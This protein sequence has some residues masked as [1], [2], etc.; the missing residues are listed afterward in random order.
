MTVLT[1]ISYITS[2]RNL[3]TEGDV[4]LSG[5]FY[6]FYYYLLASSGDLSSSNGYRA[7]MGSE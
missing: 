2:E 7:S 1:D 4:T 3:V 5:G 6:S